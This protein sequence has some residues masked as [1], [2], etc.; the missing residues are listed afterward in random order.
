VYLYRTRTR[1]NG[2]ELSGDSSPFGDVEERMHK[3]AM[4]EINGLGTY[5]LLDMR[6]ALE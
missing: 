3:E 5:E 2:V 6:R 4:F 1:R